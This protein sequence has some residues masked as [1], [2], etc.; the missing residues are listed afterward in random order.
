MRQEFKPTLA[1]M[2]YAKARAIAGDDASEASISRSTTIA[3]ETIC[4]WKSKPGF[5]EWLDEQVVVLR[6]PILDRLET[7]AMANIRDFNFWKEVARKYGYVV[8]KLDDK[9]PPSESISLTPEQLLDLVNR[10]P[11]VSE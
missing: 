2:V 8:D 11:K 4:R 5:R 10:K 1:M 7:V 6:E 3:E 9:K